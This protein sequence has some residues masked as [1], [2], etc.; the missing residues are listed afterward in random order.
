MPIE[1]FADDW[2]ACL[3]DFE[4]AKRAY[5]AVMVEGS[6][7]AQRTAA[8]QLWESIAITCVCYARP[9]NWPDGLP[10]DAATI[11][12]VPR[13]AMPPALARLLSQWAQQLMV[14]QMPLVMLDVKGPGRA[15]KGPHERQY[16]I[17]A[18]SYILSVRA[19]LIQDPHP[20]KTTAN[21]FCVTNRAVQGWLKEYFYVGPDDFGPPERLIKAFKKA[22]DIYRVNGRGA[23]ASGPRPRKLKDADRHER[24]AANKRT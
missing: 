4:Q 16:Q 19:G 21:A 10:S 14:G 3:T 18:V 11:E 12:R 8:R 23:K 2:R 9:L 24:R 5:A 15:G 22:S 1:K 20:V 13:R 7:Q 6:K 17:T